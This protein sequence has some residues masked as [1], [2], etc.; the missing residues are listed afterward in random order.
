[1]RNPRRHPQR[2]DGKDTLR[3]D[4]GDDHLD[5]GSGID[6]VIVFG[7]QAVSVNLSA[8][9]AV[10][11]GSDTFTNIENA[12]GSFRDDTITGNTGPNVLIGGSGNDTLD[13]R[14]GDD[15]LQGN[16]GD[17]HLDGGN[18][19][20]ALGGGDGTDACLTNCEG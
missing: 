18:G 12:T 14:D 3:G 19:A 7:E 17:D 1:M 13:G 10:G 8:G 11:E 16:A 6:L 20:D 2:G 5:G 9:T 15:T 4:N